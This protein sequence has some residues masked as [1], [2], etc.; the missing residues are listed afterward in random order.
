MSTTGMISL[1]A[2]CLHPQSIHHIHEAV[3]HMVSSRQAQAMGVNA[4]LAAYQA[5]GL[6][7]GLGESVHW[8]PIQLQH[9]IGAM[10]TNRVPQAGLI[11]CDTLNTGCE[12]VSI[13]VV[14]VIMTNLKLLC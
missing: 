13:P 6:A 8:V 12:T 3:V 14:V 7:L 2:L 9:V 11:S 4:G 10:L 1:P 5:A